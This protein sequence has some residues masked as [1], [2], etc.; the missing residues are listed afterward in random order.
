[1]T[2]KRIPLDILPMAATLVGCLPVEAHVARRPLSDD[3]FGLLQGTL[4]M[5][6]LQTR[7]QG[8][9]HGHQIAIT[10][11]RTS[12]DI[13]QVDHGSLYPALHRLLKRGWITGTLSTR[14][15]P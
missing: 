3:Q 6:I 5:L 2:G 15:L 13:L 4:D 14:R 11:E 10:I 9:A 12:N 7:R 8:P 1:M